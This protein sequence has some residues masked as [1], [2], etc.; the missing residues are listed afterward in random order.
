MR[1]DRVNKEKL[2]QYFR[3]E[4]VSIFYADMCP[5]FYTE[6]KWTETLGR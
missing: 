5:L 3:S 1:N 6:L 4:T 2:V